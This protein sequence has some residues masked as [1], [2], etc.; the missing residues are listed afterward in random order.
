MASRD[1]QRGSLRPPPSVMQ[2]TGRHLNAT[3]NGLLERFL[4]G[5]P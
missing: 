5:G 4:F 3:M 1:R 2:P